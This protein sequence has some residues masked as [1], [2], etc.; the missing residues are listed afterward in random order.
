MPKRREK[1]ESAG[2]ITGGGPGD[3]WCFL[4]RRV[5]AVMGVHV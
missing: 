2:N 4:S 5:E 3:I 1:E